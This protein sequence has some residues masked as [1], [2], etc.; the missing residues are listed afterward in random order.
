MYQ[1]L[2]LVD[3]RKKKMSNQSQRMEDT[4]SFQKEKKHFVSIKFQL[5]IFQVHLKLT[6]ELKSRFG[7]QVSDR[8]IRRVLKKKGLKSVEKKKKPL[9]SKK[10]IK[11]RLDFAKAHQ[12]WTSDDWERVIFSD[13]TK[14]NRFNSDGRS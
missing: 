8:T 12:Y 5:E 1:K 4:K 7:I 10:N 14:I 3:I 13:E 6:G 9:L 11:A 2:Q